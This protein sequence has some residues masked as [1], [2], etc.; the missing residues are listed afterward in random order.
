M[1]YINLAVS[2]EQVEIKNKSGLTW[3]KIVELGLKV[4]ILKGQT[5]KAAK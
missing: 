2:P 5:K 1:Q 3:A 4:S